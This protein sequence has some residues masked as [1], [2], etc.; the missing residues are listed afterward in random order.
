MTWASDVVIRDAEHGDEP[1][2]FDLAAAF[3]TS[4]VVDR[5]H[6][7]SR[8]AAMIDDAS[9]LLRVAAGNGRAVGYVAASVHPTLYANGPVGWIEELMVDP[10]H[11]R[12]GVGGL[13]ASSAERWAHER[14]CVMVALATR[15]AAEFWS[16]MGFEP[17]A[18]Y[19]RR[20]L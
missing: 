1:E 18:T 4:F 12:L 2:L 10:A 15:R 7:G 9:T 8:L 20:P 13:L 11:R 19:L 6:F 3:A 17:S 5:E 14:G 16:A